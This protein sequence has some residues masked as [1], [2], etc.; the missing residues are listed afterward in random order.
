MTPQPPDLNVSIGALTLANP[1]MTASGTFGY[2]LE[3]HSLV[4]LN[5][6]GAIIVKGLSLTPAKGNPPPR[7]V[8]TASGMLNAI[9]LE[10][11]GIDAFIT[12]KLPMLR[13][14]VTTP[15][16]VNLYGTSV[17]EYARLAERVDPVADIDALEVNISCPNVKAGGIAFGVDPD[18]AAQV[19]T[20]VRRNTAKPVMVKLS[21]NVTDI[22]AIARRVEDAGADAPVVDQYHYRNGHRHPYAPP[23]AGQCHRRPFRAGHQ[24][25]GPPHGMANGQ[26]RVDSGDRHRRDR[27][28]RGC[29]RILYCRCRGHPGGH[30]QFCESRGN[31]GHRVRN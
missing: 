6:L 24:A 13:K 11:I 8:E 10:N 4:D 20:A 25:G 2:G 23:E 12:E 14:N 28:G 19:V 7:I 1:V 15:V 29:H 31:H 5:R 27:F 26:S 17:D 30:S 16:V 21:P 18:S 22:V 3:F 9:G